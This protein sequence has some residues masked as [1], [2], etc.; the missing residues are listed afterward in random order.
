MI[1]DRDIAEWALDHPWQDPDQVEQDLLLSQAMCAIADHPTLSHELRLRG[2]T[3]FHKLFLSEP[4]RYSEDL[5]YVRTTAGGIGDVMKALT[6]LGNELGYE[7]RTSM[8]RHPKVFWRFMRNS[9]LPGKIKVEIDTYERSPMLEPMTVTHEVQS[10]FCT[11]SAEI[12]TFQPSELVATKIR[13]LYQRSKGRD[14][15]DIWLALT[16][17]RLAPDDII[18]AFPAYRPDGLTA[19]KLEQNLQAKLHDPG[20]CCDVD[21]LMRH[22]APRYDAQEAGSLVLESIVRRLP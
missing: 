3:A 17:L 9:G 7:V 10:S 4:R 13:A 11:A 22:D 14:L 19:K 18:A 6:A 15:Y 16:E 8:Q 20:F 12:S 1:T 2:G 21:V 5:D